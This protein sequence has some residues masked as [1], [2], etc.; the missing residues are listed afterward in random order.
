MGMYGPTNNMAPF[1]PTIPIL[2]HSGGIPNPMT[3]I[4]KMSDRHR[5]IMRDM[6]LSGL[7]SMDIAIKYDMSETHV[8]VLINSP[9]WKKEAAEMHDGAI[10]EYQGKVMTMIPPALETVEEIMARSTEFTLRDSD[11]EEKIAH[12]T[13]PPSA[14]IRAAELVLKAGGLVGDKKE[15]GGVKSVV[16][17]LVQPGWGNKDG[18]PNIIN[19][20]VH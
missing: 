10:S 8:S 3:E 20:E 2:P 7:R 6:V 11:G 18:K 13:N 5:A 9:L 16:L 4:Q 19:V 15:G 1:C 17:N 14:R 12:V